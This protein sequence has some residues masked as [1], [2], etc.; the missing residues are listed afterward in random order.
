ML[1]FLCIYWC[2]NSKSHSQWPNE[3]SVTLNLINVQTKL[4]EKTKLKIPIHRQNGQH[5][6][7][8]QIHSVTQSQIGEF[9][10]IVLWQLSHTYFRKY[11]IKKTSL[12][13]LFQHFILV[14]GQLT[15]SISIHLW[16]R[17]KLCVAKSNNSQTRQNQRQTAKFSSIFIYACSACP[18]PIHCIHWPMHRLVIL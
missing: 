18:V 8:E 10:S 6:R 14:F 17:S 11:T 5:A 3:N 7:N 13:M 12:S 2:E 15:E 16:R 1:G 4:M 9:Y